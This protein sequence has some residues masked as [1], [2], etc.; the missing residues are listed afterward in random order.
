MIPRHIWVL[1]NQGKVITE[2]EGII[3]LGWVE[4]PGLPKVLCWS[5]SNG[6]IMTH[7]LILVRALSIVERCAGEFG[8]VEAVVNVLGVMLDSIIINIPLLHDL[9]M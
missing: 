7:D 1:L 2:F 9:R 6:S 5:I 8:V 3:L 4:I